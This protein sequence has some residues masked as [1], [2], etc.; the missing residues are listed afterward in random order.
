MY[1]RQEWKKVVDVEKDVEIL[2]TLLRQYRLEEMHRLLS[3]LFLNKRQYQ[4]IANTCCVHFVPDCIQFMNDVCVDDVEEMKHRLRFLEILYFGNAEQEAVKEMSQMERLLKPVFVDVRWNV[5]DRILPDGFE[6]LVESRFR[7]MCTWLEIIE[8]AELVEVVYRLIGRMCKCEQL[9]HW[10]DHLEKLVEVIGQNFDSRKK[11][12]YGVLECLYMISKHTIDSVMLL[13]DRIELSEKY[14]EVERRIWIGPNSEKVE[15]YEY[16]FSELGIS[17]SENN[18]QDNWMFVGD[19]MLDIASVLLQ[20][21]AR[22]KWSKEKLQDRCVRWLKFVVSCKNTI[23]VLQVMWLVHVVWQFAPCSN[24][25][26]AIVDAM[27]L[28][29]NALGVWYDRVFSFAIFD[30]VH[31]FTVNENVYQGKISD[32][33]VL[34]NVAMATIFL[35]LS[36]VADFYTL[37]TNASCGT[38]LHFRALHYVHRNYNFRILSP[39]AVQLAITHASRTIYLTQEDVNVG[40]LATGFMAFLFV[41]KLFHISKTCPNEMS[42]DLVQL[43]SLIWVFSRKALFGSVFVQEAGALFENLLLQGAV[44]PKF[45]YSLWLNQF[46]KPSVL[47]LSELHHSRRVGRLLIVLRS[48]HAFF[49][50]NDQALSL[51]TSWYQEVDIFIHLINLLNDHEVTHSN[52]ALVHVGCMVLK[53]IRQLLQLNYAAKICLLQTLNGSS[54]DDGYTQISNRLL[55]LFDSK[56]DEKIAIAILELAVHKDFG[57]HKESAKIQDMDALL[58]VMD[59]FPYFLKEV[60]RVVI[61]FVYGLL[62]LN[63]LIGDQNRAEC[64]AQGNPFMSQIVQNMA[65]CAEISV[66]QDLSLLLA[67]LGSFQVS[68][69]LVK[70]LIR[71]T[72]PGPHQTQR[73]FALCEAMF[74]MVNDT[75]LDMK[76]ESRIQFID[77]LASVGGV[78][79]LLP[80]FSQCEYDELQGSDL[81]AAQILKLCVLIV[82]KNYE[83]TKFAQDLDRFRLLTYI[84]GRLPKRVLSNKLI[85]ACIHS[86]F[87][88]NVAKDLQ[89]M[90]FRNFLCEF[91]LWSKAVDVAKLVEF[92]T[93]QCKCSIYIS[94]QDCIDYILLPYSVVMEIKVPSCVYNSIW[95]LIQVLV[96]V[97]NGPSAM[98]IESISRLLEFE[99]IHMASALLTLSYFGRRP[100]NNSAF[101]RVLVKASSNI[102]LNR[103]MSIVSIVV[104]S[105]HKLP[106][107]CQLTALQMLLKWWAICTYELQSDSPS[108]KLADIRSD[109]QH[110]VSITQGSDS[111]IATES[112][113]MESILPKSILNRKGASK[114]NSGFKV[115]S[116]LASIG[117]PRPTLM[118][119]WLLK[120]CTIIQSTTQISLLMLI[121]SFLVKHDEYEVNSTPHCN[122]CENDS[123]HR[124]RTFAI[125]SVFELIKVLGPTKHALSILNAMFTREEN[126]DLLLS[127][128]APWQNKLID[129]ALTIA[130]DVH[131]KVC[132]DKSIAL[133]LN[134]LVRIAARPVVKLQWNAWKTFHEIFSL[135][136]VHF[137]T[138]LNAKKVY[139][140]FAHQFIV[141]LSLQVELWIGLSKQS[142]EWASLYSN[143]LH[144][145]LLVESVSGDADLCSSMMHCEMLCQLVTLLNGKIL[146][147]T[148]SFLKANIDVKVMAQHKIS[149][150]QVLVSDSQIT[151]NAPKGGFLRASLATLSNAILA[152][153]DTLDVSR[154]IDHQQYCELLFKALQQSN[155]VK[156][157]WNYIVEPLYSLLTLCRNVPAQ[158]DKFSTLLARMM[159]S[160]LSF[161]LI[162]SEITEK[163]AQA[164][165]NFSI[166][167]SSSLFQV[168]KFTLTWLTILK[169]AVHKLNHVQRSIFKQDV[170]LACFDVVRFK[171]TY[172]SK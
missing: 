8:D 149:I 71:L 17:I 90:Y 162:V 116:T 150:W 92:I 65:S 55:L 127:C 42:P 61:H 108:A 129:L 7:I 75:Y 140:L 32:S 123:I 2:K 70:S 62:P 38:Y 73:I 157:H 155:A 30:K 82:A 24:A 153:V 23:S 134:V 100:L 105:M 154:T 133:I 158:H 171:L 110:E 124:D 78:C 132:A 166:C 145:V 169:A 146:I 88:L 15:H 1:I 39:N 138:R 80:I 156:L 96:S 36:G 18:S 104:S 74:V 168:N 59:L 37:W 29:R 20:N 115:T 27:L 79:V 53:V 87:L 52:R 14:S 63:N 31:K 152:C 131:I 54:T 144:I 77:A 167:Q 68:A 143:L 126:I 114:L 165:P 120:I 159:S 76:T 43:Y 111:S 45:A 60:Q 49:N 85:D 136:L 10:D 5:E 56:I 141:E 102:E 163:Q 67:N 84:I 128:E 4:C 147:Q 57:E 11:G 112:L 142:Q 66:F 139:A 98:Q 81:L 122:I 12:V 103:H 137:K 109:K 3:R 172:T 9:N 69:P 50:K 35:R 51:S 22:D 94:V 161:K 99:S 119:L 86:F 121:A 21:I 89:Q 164:E 148:F 34:E 83:K 28:N 26:N 151:R 113:C 106:N 130:N 170:E 58:L 13:V 91:S 40:E 125:P 64:S 72:R 117:F 107:I 93:E 135:F 16:N 44:F 48:M 95:N 97:S 46:F 25:K 6:M 33:T 41:S 101:T 160:N 118:N 47:L 19:G